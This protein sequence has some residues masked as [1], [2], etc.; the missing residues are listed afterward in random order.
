MDVDKGSLRLLKDLKKGTK[1]S[2][3]LGGGNMQRL[4]VAKMKSKLMIS[5]A[6]QGIHLDYSPP[7]THPPVH[8]LRPGVPSPPM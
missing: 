2:K 5:V 7:K 4:E 8:N 1:N 3:L 6:V